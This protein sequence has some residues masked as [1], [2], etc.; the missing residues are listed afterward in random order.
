MHARDLDQNLLHVQT[1]N[2]T[3]HTPLF[4]LMLSYILYTADI[5][6]AQLASRA[7]MQM[8]V[9]GTNKGPTAQTVFFT[10][11]GATGNVTKQVGEWS[12]QSL[13]FR[14]LILLIQQFSMPFNAQTNVV[15]YLDC[16]Y[17]IGKN[18]ND[19]FSDVQTPAIDS[20]SPDAIASAQCAIFGN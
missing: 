2:M 5:C 14:C 15:K 20:Q 7:G 1:N 16:A 9:V 3:H 18:S 13:Q 10:V 6:S 12:S 17:G 11:D 8:W 4:F 19:Q